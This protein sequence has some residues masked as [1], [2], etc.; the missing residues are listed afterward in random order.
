[1]MR[2]WI[3]GALLVLFVAVAITSRKAR[4]F[5]II[6]VLLMLS[7]C[8]LEFAVFSGWAGSFPEV[9]PEAK[10]AYA[11]RAVVLLCTAVALF[12]AAVG[13]AGWRVVVARRRILEK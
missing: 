7:Y 2:Y 9:P 10:S 4:Y 11:N 1:M 5:S 13:L 12:L 3:L 6:S 8:A